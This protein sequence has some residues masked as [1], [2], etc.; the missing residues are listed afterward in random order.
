MVM[1]EQFEIATFRKDVASLDGRH[2]QVQYGNVSLQE[3]LARRD[4]T[5]NAMAYD[6]AT[7]DVVDPYNGRQDIANGIIRT[8]ENADRRFQEDGPRILRVFRFAAQMGFSIDS[9][10]LSAATRMRDMLDR[11]SPERKFQELS[12]ILVSDPHMLSM[13]EQAGVLTKVMPELSAAFSTPQNSKWHYGNVGVHSV[14]AAA[15]IEPDP[16]LRWAMI[17]HDLGKITTRTTDEDGDHFY[18]H[19]SVSAEMAEKIL[20]GF[21][22]SNDFI[23]PVVQLV[24]DHDKDILTAKAVRK[25]VSNHGRESLNHLIQV[26]RADALA[27]SDLARPYLLD[28]VANLQ[29]IAEMVQAESSR[30]T[31][32]DLAINGR[33]LLAL[34]MRQ[35]PEIGRALAKALDAVLED[36]TKNNR[37]TL[38]SIIAVTN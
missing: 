15:A 34:G 10:T 7:G 26:K 32:K 22:C 36:P 3:D 19:P 16:M 2:A 5:I 1:G 37:Q 24:A 20:R 6:L 4:L 27:H 8:V 30:I 35:G 33:D 17:L 14:D 9:E 12:K 28:R 23:E 25:Y 11:V 38:L 13:M 18:G 21:H 31:V 29:K